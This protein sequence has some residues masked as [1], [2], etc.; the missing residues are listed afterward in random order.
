MDY[1]QAFLNIDILS[2]NVTI[3]H[4]VSVRKM[5]NFL[6]KKY[7]CETQLPERKPTA[8]DI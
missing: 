3:F 2:Q 6:K 4:V 8:Y 5:L 7:I 1:A